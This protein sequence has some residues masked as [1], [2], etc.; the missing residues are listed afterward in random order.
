[1]QSVLLELT[2]GIMPRVNTHLAEHGTLR[3]WVLTIS[4]KPAKAT[5]QLII[6]AIEKWQATEEQ[7]SKAP[8]AADVQRELA[9]LWR[10]SHLVAK[11]EPAATIKRFANSALKARD[12]GH[13]NPSQADPG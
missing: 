13:Y 1:M 6:E 4:R 9:R 2:P 12:N 5:G 7:I 11:D 8:P 10:M 3:Y